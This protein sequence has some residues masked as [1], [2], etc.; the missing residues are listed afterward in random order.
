[1]LL[2]CVRHVLVVVAG[3]CCFCGFLLLNALMSVL[4][5]RGCDHLLYVRLHWT[6]VKCARICCQSSNPVE[7]YDQ[8][9][10]LYDYCMD[11]THIH[12]RLDCTVVY[13]A[14]TQHLEQCSSALQCLYHFYRKSLTDAVF[15]A[16]RNRYLVCD[17]CNAVNSWQQCWQ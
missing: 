4:L 3:C 12:V 10:A 5:I 15:H 11:V 1:M 6:I 2:S 7:R 17:D 16:G 13:R 8:P 9:S 14:W